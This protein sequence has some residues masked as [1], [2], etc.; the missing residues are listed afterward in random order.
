M[1]AR[2]CNICGSK[3]VIA[4]EQMG[5]GDPYYLAVCSGFFRCKSVAW[6]VCGKGDTEQEAVDSFHKRTTKAF[7]DRPKAA[8][9]PEPQP[10]QKELL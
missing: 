5:L 8:A 4:Y 3:L 6:N 9:K 10:E 2:T 1:S 7:A